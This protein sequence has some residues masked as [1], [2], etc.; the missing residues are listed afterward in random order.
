MSYCLPPMLSILTPAPHPWCQAPAWALHHDLED[1]SGGLHDSCFPVSLYDEKSNTKFS[2]SHEF[3]KYN[4]SDVFILYCCIAATGNDFR[5]LKSVVHVICTIL[6]LQLCK[7]VCISVV[8]R[9][10]YW[11]LQLLS[12]DVSKHTPTKLLII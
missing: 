2:L 10:K 6:K 7:C 3:N 9:S 1:F 4:N 11:M 5:I 12:Q 8:Q